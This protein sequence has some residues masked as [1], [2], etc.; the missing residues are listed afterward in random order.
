M[1]RDFIEAL[2]R[3]F[4]AR[5]NKNISLIINIRGKSIPKEHGSILTEFYDIDEADQI[6]SGM[7]DAGM[8]VQVYTNETEF[9]K[10][11]L[12]G[13]NQDLIA[14][15][16]GRNGVS[17]TKKSLIP[18]ICSANKLK[19]TGSDAYVTALC[20]NKFHYTLLLESLGIKVP[21]TDIHFCGTKYSTKNMLTTQDLVIVKP[22][23]EAASRGI[24]NS[25]ILHYS[26]SHQIKSIVSELSKEF[27]NSPVLVQEFIE[28]FEIE[29]PIFIFNK[30][31]TALMPVGLSID[32]VCCIGNKIL[33]Y[34][35]SAFYDYEFY[36]Y[37]DE[38]K[39]IASDIVRHAERAAMLLGLTGYGRIDF[40]VDLNGNFYLIDISTHPFIMEHSSFAFALNKMGVPYSDLFKCIIE[41][42][43]DEHP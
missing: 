26:D 20:R 37:R 23:Y 12:M 5:N 1:E 8:S 32:N 43:L 28:G 11:K 34:E 39:K 25:S 9:L 35:R 3:A 21:K 22:A 24:H 36:D 42:S 15:N 14:F 29:V 7:K 41:C 30:K 38:N 16:M 6:L 2:V 17:L 4:D 31:A 10:M 18:M 19:Y 27:Y 40:R 33:D 13:Q